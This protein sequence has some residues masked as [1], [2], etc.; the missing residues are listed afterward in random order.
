MA[1]LVYS[2]QQKVNVIGF[3]LTLHSCMN[4]A[5]GRRMC[6]F[7]FWP[8]ICQKSRLLYWPGTWHSLTLV[9][10]LPDNSVCQLYEIFRFQ[11][12]IT[13]LEQRDFYHNRPTIQSYSSNSSSW[14]IYGLCL[15]WLSW[16]SVSAWKSLLKKLIPTSCCYPEHTV[17]SQYFW[18]F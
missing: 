11:D 5:D 17:A 14:L 16:I 3:G 1:P 15:I 9:S 18:V 2:E 13:L 12:G 8:R 7:D 6:C 4:N 10:L